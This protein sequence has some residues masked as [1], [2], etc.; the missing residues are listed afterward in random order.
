MLTVHIQIGVPIW[1]WDTDKKMRA[2][3]QEHRQYLKDK[4]IV[5]S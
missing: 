1:R 5:P 4:G 3:R 2:H